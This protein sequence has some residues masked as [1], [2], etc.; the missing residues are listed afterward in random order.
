M[1]GAGLDT[2][3]RLQGRYRRGSLSNWLSEVYF[4]RET[5]A[6]FSTHDIQRLGDLLTKM[7]CYVPKDRLSTQDI[8]K[9]EWFKT[10]P[11]PSRIGTWY[12]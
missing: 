8:L 5:K 6:E 9:H 3:W 7:M 4:D 10:N 1:E 12:W 2:H 11:L